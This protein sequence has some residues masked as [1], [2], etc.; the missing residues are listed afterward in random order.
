MLWS[1]PDFFP[2]MRVEVPDDQFAVQV[3]SMVDSM[4]D[5]ALGFGTGTPQSRELVVTT[6]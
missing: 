4:A 2:Q 6:T 1:L 3:D 5:S